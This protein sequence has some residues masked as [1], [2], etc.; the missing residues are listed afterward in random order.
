MKITSFNKTKRQQIFTL[1]LVNALL[2]GTDRNKLPT[3]SRPCFIAIKN[4]IIKL[5]SI[6]YD[7]Q[8]SPHFKKREYNKFQRIMRSLKNYIANQYPD[9]VTLD[10]LNAL[11]IMVFDISDK[12]KNT[13][14]K[15][16][17][18]EIGK[19]LETVF[20]HLAGDY[21]DESIISKSFRVKETL[22]QIIE[23]K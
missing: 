10:F 3:K 11:L 22:N 18:C 13:K 14:E 19:L 4:R 15:Q 2:N 8:K 1:E 16:Y 9:I 6:L 17:W 23:G 5:Q 7:N 21:E 20:L 12:I